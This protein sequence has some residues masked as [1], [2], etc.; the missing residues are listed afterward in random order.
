MVHLQEQIDLASDFKLMYESIQIPIYYI[1]DGKRIDMSW[2]SGDHD[3]LPFIEIENLVLPYIE[4]EWN[5]PLI[6]ALNSWE[7]LILLPVHRDGK[8]EGFAV[9]GPAIQQMPEAELIQGFMKDNQLSYRDLTRWKSY[10]SSLPL[11]SRLRMLHIS[12]LAHRIINRESIEITDVLQHNCHIVLPLSDNEIEI[13]VS[14]QRELSISRHSLALEKQFMEL[15]REG[16]TAELT[17]LWTTFPSEG[18][19]LLSKKSQLRNTKNLAICLITIVTRAAVDGGLYEE[20][21]FRLSDLYIQQIEEMNDIKTVDALGFRALLDFA[22]RVEQSQ[23]AGISKPVRM[24]LE[25]IFNHLY[26]EITVEQLAE[27]TS[28][29][30]SYLMH[31]FKQQMGVTLANYIQEQRIEEAKKLL[32]ITNDTALSIGMRLNFYDQSHFIKVFKKMTGMTPKQYRD[33]VMG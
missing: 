10:W 26:Q 11:V 25:H 33:T 22:E 32:R 12:V 30:G 23:K 24:C 3:S 6:L 13:N 31:L 2:G 28:L 27:L 16:K 19:G 21:A 5:Q 29:N 4:G 7:Q 18:V 15:I 1:V 17:R 14:T 9:I 8:R 20:L